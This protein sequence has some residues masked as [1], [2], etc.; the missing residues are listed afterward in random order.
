MASW[1]FL[2]LELV[3]GPSCT[4][5]GSWISLGFELGFTSVGYGFGGEC[6]KEE[7]YESEF[8]KN[9]SGADELVTNSAVVCSIFLFISLNCN[10]KSQ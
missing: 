5:N 1:S 6:G 8:F 10:H 7:C 3:I 9:I 2:D 4:I